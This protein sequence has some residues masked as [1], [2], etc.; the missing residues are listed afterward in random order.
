[1]S[2]YRL[3]QCMVLLSLLGLFGLGARA[4]P[5]LLVEIRQEGFSDVNADGEPVYMAFVTETSGQT[6]LG[7]V[8]GTGDVGMTFEASPSVLAGIEMAFTSGG[9]FWIDNDSHAP[10][11]HG[12]DAI[13]TIDPLD[14][15]I[16]R[17]VPRRGHGLTGYDLTNVTQTIDRLEYVRSGDDIFADQAQ[18]IRFYGEVVPEPGLNCLLLTAHVMCLI[19]RRWRYSS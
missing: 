11:T 15:E 6:A 1:M 13:W 8:Y 9:I 5:L 18:T 17:H 12:V 2:T 19:T 4:E 10:A 14:W 16:S 3:D 7:R